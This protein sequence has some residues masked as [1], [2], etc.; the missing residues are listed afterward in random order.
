MT[1]KM[2]TPFWYGT[3]GLGMNDRNGAGAASNFVGHYDRL[4]NNIDSACETWSRGYKTYYQHKLQTV[5]K[6]KDGKAMIGC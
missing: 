6:V 4:C 2:I 5:A 3:V 1:D